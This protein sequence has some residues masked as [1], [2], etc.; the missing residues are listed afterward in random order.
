MRNA[1]LVFMKS[2][3]NLCYRKALPE[4]ADGYVGPKDH[5]S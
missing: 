2:M 5:L 1:A 4:S 3:R